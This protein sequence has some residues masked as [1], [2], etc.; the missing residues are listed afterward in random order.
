M[1]AHFVWAIKKIFFW[2]TPDILQV[3]T[4]NLLPKALFPSKPTIT[5]VVGGVYFVRYGNE[6]FFTRAPRYLKSCMKEEMLKKYTLP[7]FLEVH[8]GDTVVDVGAF[9]GG[10][11]IAAASK[12][13]KV[14]AIEPDPQNFRIL[15][16]N[17][18]LHKLRNVLLINKALWNKTCRMK[19]HLSR[20]PT[21]SSLLKTRDQNL[22][23]YEEIEA[24]RLDELASRL[25]IERIDFLKMDAEGAEIEVLKGTDLGKTKGVAIDCSPERFGRSPIHGVKR[26]LERAGFDIRVVGDMIYARKFQRKH[27]SFR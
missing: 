22:D 21:S 3:F 13:K 7:G 25:G 20:D 8:K 15:E 12:A 27:D 17:V 16:M 5:R 24:I 10:F 26:I 1:G 2:K 11:S 14:V 19:L 4:I 9:V 23:K 6:C 18:K